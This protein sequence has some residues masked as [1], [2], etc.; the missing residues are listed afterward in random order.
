MPLSGFIER[1]EI[2]K[3]ASKMDVWLLRPIELTYWI[4]K[5]LIFTFYRYYRLNDTIKLE[6][7][8]YSE[9]LKGYVH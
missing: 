9:G 6:H 8:F 4:K 2:L 5:T 7:G 1:F 3:M